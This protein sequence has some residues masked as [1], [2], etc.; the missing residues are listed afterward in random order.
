MTEPDAFLDVALLPGVKEAATAARAALDPMLL[1]RRLRRHGAALATEAALRNAHASATFDGAEV[2][3]DE[4]SELSSAS[5]VMRVASAV[6][7]VQT[8]LRTLRGLPARQVWASIAA[9]SGAEYLSEDERG[10]PRAEGSAL[11]DPLHLGIELDLEDAAVRLALLA[12][13]LG[14]PTKAPALVV[15]A[16]V[17][18]ELLALQPFGASNGVVARAYSHY[19]LAERG[20]DPDFF[21]MTDVGLI[22]L[23]RAAYV[24]ALR[25]YGTG[26]SEGI[27]N[28]CIHI[29]SAFERG[30]LLSRQTLDT[31]AA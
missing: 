26:G 18:G 14:Q 16:L 22:S 7:E 11:H 20:M 23:G 28:W 24:R 10:R 12:E 21:A 5:P 25:G 4:L 9:A 8:G 15:A 30:A 3:I 1:D 19:V 27:A 2:P 29:A 17:H 6:L 13:L 31:L